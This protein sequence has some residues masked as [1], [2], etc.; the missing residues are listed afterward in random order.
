MKTGICI[1]PV[2]TALAAAFLTA[3]GDAGDGGTSAATPA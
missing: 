1:V 3:C 2:A